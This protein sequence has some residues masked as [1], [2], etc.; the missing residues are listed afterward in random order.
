MQWQRCN[1]ASHD[2]Q[3][4]TARFGH[5]TVA[6]TSGSVWGTELAVVFG[7]VSHSSGDPSQEQHT[8]LA[9]VLVLQPQANAW[10]CPQVGSG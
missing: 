4:V 9:D 10:F 6:I 7:G 5:S 8:A 3:V 2:G 1:A